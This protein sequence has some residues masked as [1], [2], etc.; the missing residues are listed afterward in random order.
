MSGQV[1]WYSHVFK[2]FPQFVV[3]HTVKG[4]SYGW[5]NGQGGE[6]KAYFDAKILERR[7]AVR[8]QIDP[9]CEHKEVQK[10]GFK[11]WCHKI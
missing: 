1:V 3:I 10:N 2:N 5:D 6:K 9:N 8:E 4:Y 7:V 11:V